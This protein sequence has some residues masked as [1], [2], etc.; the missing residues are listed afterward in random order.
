MVAVI[1]SPF[2]SESHSNRKSFRMS[3]THLSWTEPMFF[4]PR[5]RTRNE[6]MWRLVWFA[7]LT[8]VIWLL[9]QF[10]L[11]LQPWTKSL[12]AGAGF[13]LFLTFIVDLLHLQREVW[14]TDNAIEWKAG[15]GQYWIIGSHPHANTARLQFL[16]A[17][18]RPACPGFPL[19]SIHR[20]VYRAFADDP[21]FESGNS[22]ASQSTG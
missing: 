12:L 10:G 4:V 14:I 9:L 20:S 18:V 16:R 8:L 3:Q 17:G 21:V 7:G 13:G 19:R 6:W 22:S 1:F 2:D 5:L 15:G 11:G